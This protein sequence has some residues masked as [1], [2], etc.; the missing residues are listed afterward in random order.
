M[1]NTECKELREILNLGDVYKFE[2]LLFTS[3]RTS[4]TERYEFFLNMETGNTVNFFI[5]SHTQW[6]YSPNANVDFDIL[7]S[8]LGNAVVVKELHRSEE[9]MYFL[10]RIEKAK[11]DMRYAKQNEESKMLFKKS[12]YSNFLHQHRQ[13][14]CLF[15]TGLTPQKETKRIGIQWEFED[16]LISIGEREDSTDKFHTTKQH[17]YL[18]EKCVFDKETYK[19]KLAQIINDTLEML[20]NKNQNKFYKGLES[21]ASGLGYDSIA[22]LLIEEEVLYFSNFKEIVFA[23]LKKIDLIVDYINYNIVYSSARVIQSN[24]TIVYSVLATK[25]IELDS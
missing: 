17:K 24:D 25:E 23:V 7:T 10:K 21:N 22:K 6:N 11:S 13:D 4:P 2:E 8:Y 19:D 20:P 18:K 14:N 5:S 9:D 15:C 12:G 3:Y 1:L 16:K